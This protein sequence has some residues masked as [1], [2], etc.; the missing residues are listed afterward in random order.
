M[1]I[2]VG[3]P[4]RIAFIHSGLRLLIAMVEV[5]QLKIRDQTPEY[6]LLPTTV[7]IEMDNKFIGN[8]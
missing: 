3:Y 6:P 5:A 8:L 7:K 2:A 4:V 1:M